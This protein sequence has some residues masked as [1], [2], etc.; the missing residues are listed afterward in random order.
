MFSDSFVTLCQIVERYR[1]KIDLAASIPPEEYAKRWQAV[2]HHLR[3]RD[4]DLGL[5]YFYREMPGDGMYLTGYNPTIERACGAIGQ[6]GAPVI[7][8]GPEAGEVAQESALESGA[9]VAYAEEFQIPDEYYAHVSFSSIRDIL[10]RAAGGVQIGRIGWLTDGHLFPE[11][12][13]DAIRSALG[14]TAEYVDA[15]DVLHELRHEKSHAELGLMADA[16]AIANAAARAMLAVAR[17]D[18]RETQLAAVGDGAMK[19]LGATSYGFET[20]VNSGPRCRTII[21][22]ASNRVMQ[23]GEMVQIGVSPGLSGYKGVCRRVFVLGQPTALQ[24]TFLSHLETAFAR[25]RS[26]LQS[27][28]ETGGAPGQIDRAARE[29]FSSVQLEGVPMDRLMNYSAMHGTGL[30]E[31]MEGKPVTPYT[32]EPF[33][34]RIGMML[35]VGAYGHPHDAIAGG[36]IENAFAKDGATLLEMTDLPALVQPLVGHRG[37]CA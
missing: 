16:N 33:G 23:A 25:A 14:S 3:D 10:V 22:A 26:A 15:S 30:T 5:F 31:C 7:I 36:C 32:T 17:P 8:A 35:D 12:L 37:G 1:S 20:I 27:V 2:Q 4:L 24:A 19:S 21:G 9:E 11:A 28:V 18:M 6:T 29:Y 34:H 13:R